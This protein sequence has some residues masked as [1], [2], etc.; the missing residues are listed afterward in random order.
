[1]PQRHPAVPAWHPIGTHRPPVHDV[2]AA[3]H[4]SPGPQGQP[5]APVAQPG[6]W[7][8]PSTHCSAVPSCVPQVGVGSPPASP[9]PAGPGAPLLDDDDDEPVVAGGQPTSGNAS[10]STRPATTWEK[11]PPG[12]AAKADIIS[13]LD[14]Q[15]A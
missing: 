7:H 10:A 6:T 8:V 9:R 15:P 2:P 13:D 4:V 5:S 3:V 11:V 1:S 14:E 12:G